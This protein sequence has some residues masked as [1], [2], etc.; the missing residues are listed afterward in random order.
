[1]HV[2]KK[3]SSSMTVFSQQIPWICSHIPF[4][5]GTLES[6]ILTFP[7]REFGGSHVILPCRGIILSYQVSS[8]PASS[9]Q[10]TW[11]SR[12][13][14]RIWG[15]PWDAPLWY[16]EILL[17]KSRIVQVIL[18]IWIQSK[19]YKKYRLSLSH[20]HGK[21]NSR[22][23]CPLTNLRPSNTSPKDVGSPPMELDA[24]TPV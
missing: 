23:F 2:Q 10:F 4:P 13:Q 12:P 5:A 14:V 20:T 15:K 7:S 6:M 3:T 17:S 9:S 22:I 19:T 21:K 24:E 8:C 16:H 1:M 11:S 18:N